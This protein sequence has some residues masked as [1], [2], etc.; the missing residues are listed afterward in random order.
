MK[1]TASDR[2]LGRTPTTLWLPSSSTRNDTAAFSAPPAVPVVSGRDAGA[3]LLPS[4]GVRSAKTRLF[5]WTREDAF[6]RISVLHGVSSK[7]VEA[8]A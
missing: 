1:R 4:A 2:S 5:A 6:C 3:A 8:A 7:S